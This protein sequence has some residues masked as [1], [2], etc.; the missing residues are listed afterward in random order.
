VSFSVLSTYESSLI[1]NKYDFIEEKSSFYS[2]VDEKISFQRLPL[3]NFELLCLTFLLFVPIFLVE[4]MTLKWKRAGKLDFEL[5]TLR[6][7]FF[8]AYCEMNQCQRVA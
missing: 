2:F 1:T 5:K 4:Q 8:P 7:H 3:G 6:G